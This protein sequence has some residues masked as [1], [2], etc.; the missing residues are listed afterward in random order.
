MA[1]FVHLTNKT[2]YSLSE[3]AL[4]IARIAE[5]CQSF[6]MPAVGISDNNN[7]FGALEFSEQIAKIGVQPILG[8][9][10]KIKTP[11]EYLHE[12]IEDNDLYFYLN[13]FSKS[14]QGYENLLKCVS[15]AYTLNKGNAYITIDDLIKFKEGL[16]ILSGGN[17]SILSHSTGRMITKQSKQFVSDFKSEFNDNFYIEIQRLGSVDYRLDEVAILNL[18]YDHHI[19]LV[20]TNDAYF[21]GPEYFEA[22]DA[23]M[24]IEKK[25]FVSQVDRSRLSKEHYFK[26]QN[27]MLELFS[28]LPEALNNTIEIAQ[29]CIHRPKI[30]NP[31]LPVYDVDQNKEKEL[32]QKLSKQGLDDR[33]NVKFSTENID[34]EKQKD[35]RSVYEERL[36]KELK[37]IINMKYEGYFLIVSDFILWAK[38]NDIP[39]GPGRG[40]GAGSLVAWCLNITDLDPIKFGL[41]FERF[42]NPE[43]VSLPDFDIDFCRDGRDRVLEYVHNKYGENKVA[44]IITFGKLQARAVIR[45]VGRVLGIPY[46]QVDY[47]CKLMPFDPSR[48][49][50]LQKYI[51]EEPKLNEEA[52]RDPKIKKL[53]DI[54]LKLEGLKR[55][56]SIHAAGVVISRDQISKDVPLYSD[57][58][59]NIFLTQFDMKWVENAG[60]VKFDFL[61]LKTLTLINECIKLVRNNNSDFNIDKININDLK[62]YELLSTGET[63][64]I[65]QLESAGM[66][67]TL[68]Q[69]KPDKFEDII[70]IVALYRPGPMANIPSYIERKHGREKPDYIHPLLEGL[71]KETYGVVIYQ[72]QVM[73]V[74]RELSGYSDGEADLLRRAMGKKIQKEMKAQ[75]ERFISGCLNNKL[76]NNEAEK[77]FELLSKFADYGF[78]KSHAAAYAL[79]AFQTAFLKAHF[80]IEFFAAS[81]S[82]DINNTDKISIFQQELVRMNIKLI[83]PSINQSNSYFSRDGEKISYA[84]GAI[85]NV[86]IE[87]MNDLMNERKYDGEFENFSDFI[88]RCN[89]SIINKKTLEALACAGAFDEFSVNRASVF[90]Q[91]QDIVKFHKSQNNKSSSE[92]E[93]MFGDIGLSHFSINDEEEWSYPYKLMKEYEMLGF[94]LT[95][96][97]LEA[98]KKNYPSLML[99]EFSEIKK[100]ESAYNQK[101]VLLGGTLLSK[102]EKRSARGNAYAF[103]N[104]SDLSSIYELIV[105]E[106]NLRKYRDL[107]VEGESFIISVDFSFQNGTLR[108]EL[109]K[110]FN[111][112]DVENLNLKKKK[113]ENEE[114]V[115]PLIKIYTDGN[116]TKDE[117]LKLKWLKGMQKVEIIYDNQLLK[118]PG[119]FEISADMIEEIKNLN[120]VKKIELS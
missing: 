5:L 115:N 92:Q 16:I 112:D 8:C 6:S 63:T 18:A 38:N 2:E 27:E 105:F 52:N 108:G 30:K 73:G 23:L 70:A 96:H 85:K 11:K 25:L 47:L 55:H 53:L 78:N 7:M 36:L 68:K 103:L 91:A 51:D 21:E 41:I 72:E 37:I 119:A 33:L 26:S 28:D 17:N 56:A 50:S 77:I 76:K 3:G 43:R 111:F 24:C 107:L 99:K 81:M 35:I 19:P 69:L 39:V 100:N 102:K 44:Q 40:S 9:N 120:G 104:F 97:P 54:S 57:P 109:K 13:I 71:L 95:G 10:I 117:L 15:N 110:I 42:L 90:N 45:D 116:F 98:Q 83:P 1:D 32:M 79:I 94:Y 84:L 59:S 4:P 31:I 74:A 75:K 60:L 101:D 113:V 118:I 86:G 61:G 80:P 106:S 62:T 66:K 64:G 34:I 12:N 48:P 89:T 87:S 88:Q 46:G 93:D 22:H 82:L 14:N 65:F 29:R 114:K 20:A 49:M 58:E 67:D